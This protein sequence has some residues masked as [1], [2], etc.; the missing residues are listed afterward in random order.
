MNTGMQDAVNLAWKL[1]AALKEPRSAPLLDSYEPERIAF[2]QR[3]VAT[4]DR[5]FT[6]VISGSAFARFVRTKAVPAIAPGLLRLPAMRRLAFRTVSQIGVNYRGGPLSRGGAGKLR[7]GDRLPWVKIGQGQEHNFAPLTSMD[8]QLHVYGE[9]APDLRTI[10]DGRKIPLHVFPWG[11]GMRHA[12][13]KRDAAYLIRP[14]GYI[15]LV[16][17]AGSATPIGTYLSENNLR[18]IN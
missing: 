3:L 9:A 15:G 13:L 4:T 17:S 2:A 1:A 14:D 6:A 11:A 18:T 5:A 7:G 16:D 12:G 8:W 10:A